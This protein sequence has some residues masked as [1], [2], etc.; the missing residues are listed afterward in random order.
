[1]PELPEVESARATIEAAARRLVVRGFF[2]EVLAKIGV[3][4]LRERLEAAI[5]TE[6]EAVG[7]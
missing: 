4:A 1:M 2:G 5:E 7:A 6:L 3:P